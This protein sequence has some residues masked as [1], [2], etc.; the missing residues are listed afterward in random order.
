MLKA[1]YYPL[2]HVLDYHNERGQQVIRYC[3][4][5][6]IALFLINYATQKGMTQELIVKDQA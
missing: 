1:V 6:Q 3:A 4:N 5:L 2:N